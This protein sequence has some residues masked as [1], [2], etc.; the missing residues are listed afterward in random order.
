MKI[1]FFFFAFFI[2]FTVNCY[3]QEIGATE[4]QKIH[5]SGIVKDANSGYALAN[6]M[7]INKT[8]STGFFCGSDGRFS[9]YFLKNDSLIFSVVNYKT[10]T[11]CFRDSLLSNTYEITVQMQGLIIDLNQVDIFPEKSFSEIQKQIDELGVDYHYKVQGINAISSPITF[12]YERFSRF[13]QQKKIAAEL[14][15]EDN[16]KELLKD[17][18][19]KYIKADIIDLN[20]KDF[21]AFIFF[22]NLPQEFIQNASQYELTITIKTKYAQF[23]VLN[24]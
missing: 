20:E 10:I 11:L 13:E 12:L 14:Y 4:N 5:V 15:N 23:L 18:F 9:H 1:S 22:C 8:S 24:K 19:K 3:A 21:E 2:L 6:L 7:I 16:K 17:L